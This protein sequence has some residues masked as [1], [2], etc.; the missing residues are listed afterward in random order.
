MEPAW[1]GGL[2]ER[3]RLRVLPGR[4]ARGRRPPPCVVGVLLSPF[5]RLPLP[6]AY[7]TRAMTVGPAFLLF[8]FLCPC[9]MD[10][11]PTQKLSGFEIVRFTS[12]IGL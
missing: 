4:E 10:R 11:V 9:T 6:A 1:V 3:R 2:G 5:V 7:P 12:W 8:L